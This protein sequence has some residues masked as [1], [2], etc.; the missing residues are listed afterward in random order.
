MNFGDNKNVQT[1]AQ[2]HI[3]HIKGKNH[4]T[5]STDAKQAFTKHLIKFSTHTC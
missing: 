4:M 3:N 2:H 5:I 1:M